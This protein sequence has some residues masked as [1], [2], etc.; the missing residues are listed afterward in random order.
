MQNNNP[1]PNQGNPDTAPAAPVVQPEP[2]HVVTHDPS[3]SPE[4]DRR[5]APPPAQKDGNRANG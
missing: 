4:E 5:D 3:L 2:T 1:N